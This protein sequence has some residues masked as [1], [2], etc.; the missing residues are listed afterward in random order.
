MKPLNRKNQKPEENR[1]SKPEANLQNKQNRPE[2]NLQGGSETNR[3]EMP[4]ANFQERSQTNRQETPQANLQGRTEG[5]QDV[6]NLFEAG[7]NDIYSAEKALAQ[8]LPTMMENATSPEL[9]NTL[10]SNIATTAQHINRLEKIFKTAGLKATAKK[11]ENVEGILKETE[12]VLNQNQK[13]QAADAGI[14]AAGQKLKQYEVSSLGNLHSYAQSLGQNKVVDLLAQ[15]LNEAQQS[16]E[17]FKGFAASATNTQSPSASSTGRPT[18]NANPTDTEKW[19]P[20]AGSNATENPS[21]EW[22]PGA[23]QNP[24]EKRN[25]NKK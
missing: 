6:R 24:N 7:L 10:K 19:T 9:R 21:D 4:Q 13:G 22:T 17:A 25:P 1:Q 23:K 14:I 16:H 2:A 12:G 3:Q 20:N 15:T 11:S 18:A 5:T 8:K